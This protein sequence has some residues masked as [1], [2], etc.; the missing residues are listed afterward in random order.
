MKSGFIGI[1]GRPNVGKSSLTNALVGEKV[2][3]VSLKAQTTRDSILGIV[4]ENDC[5]MIFVDTPGVHKPKSRLGEYMEQ[6]IE[7]AQ[8]DV[9]VIAVVL[10]ATRKIH[11]SELEFIEKHLKKKIPVYVVINKTDLVSYDTV[12]PMLSK[13]AYLTNE[14]KDRHAIKE[15]VPA[16]ARTGENVELLKR[17]L[18]SELPE[19]PAYYP[20]DEYT[21]KSERYM[22]CEIIREKALLFLQDEVPHGIGVAVQKVE[23]GNKL[24]NIEADIVCEK[25]SHKSIVIGEG[26]QKLKR[27]GESARTGIEKLLGRKVYLKLFVKVRDDWRNRKSFLSDIGY[28]LKK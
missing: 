7:G 19:G 22:I 8:R 5:Q 13:L 17:C 24:T 2:S 26:G 12:Y 25:K 3:I 1:L 4:T 23:E 10:D 9:D 20:E 11:D 14:T 28:K 18:A 6:C 16:S 15:I 27:I 21:D